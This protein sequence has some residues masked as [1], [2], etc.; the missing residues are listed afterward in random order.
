MLKQK[1]QCCN[2]AIVL[3]RGKKS[4]LKSLFKQLNSI[5]QNNHTCH[6]VSER[7]LRRIAAWWH[8][9]HALKKQSKR[10][11]SK[12]FSKKLLLYM[13][14]YWWE[15]HLRNTLIFRISHLWC[16]K[17]LSHTWEV[18]VTG[19]VQMYFRKKKKKTETWTWKIGKRDH[20]FIHALT[21]YVYM[22][23]YI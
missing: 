8:C 16:V 19:R 22:Y 6:F 17:E 21:I 10:V 23:I 5:H 12:I 18:C 13:W 14:G 11:W 3:S 20:T 9:S 1:E 4:I 2:R 15:L 7:S